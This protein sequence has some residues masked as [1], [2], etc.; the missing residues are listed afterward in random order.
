MAF[1]NYL[2]RLIYLFICLIF[3]QPISAQGKVNIDATVKLYQTVEDGCPTI[4][5]IKDDGAIKYQ[6]YRKSPDS[7]TWGNNYIAELSSDSTKY[8][9]CDANIQLVYEY[10]VIKFLESGRGYGFMSTG[11][12]INPNHFKGRVLMLIDKPSYDSIG[13]EIDRF[14]TVIKSEGWK[15]NRLII[16][17]DSSVQFIKSE[18]YKTIE[19][20]GEI[21]RI[22]IL[23]HVAVPHSGNIYPDGH[24]NHQGAWS[25]D[26]YYG[27]LDGNWTDASI[28]NVSSS[29]SNNHNIPNDGRFDQ[30]NIPSD[31]DIAVGRVDFYDLPAFS[32]NEFE[33]LRKYIQKSIAYRTKQFIPRRRALVQDNFNFVEAFGQSGLRGFSTLVS[34]DSIEYNNFGDA[35]NGSYLWLYGAGGGSYSSASGICNT[36]KLASDSLQGVFTLLFGSYFG[37]YDS[38]NNLMRSTIASGTA[39]SCAWAGRPHWAIH[40]MAMGADLG[41]CTLLSQNNN[42]LYPT[43]FSPRSVHVNLIGDPTL[44]SFVVAPPSNLIATEENDGHIL[45]E[46]SMSGEKV[47]G[48][49]L[50]KRNINEEQ[51]ELVTGMLSDRFYIDSCLHVGQKLEYL[52]RAVKVERTS[53]GSYYNLSGGPTYQITPS[54]DHSV[55]ADFSYLSEGFILTTTNTSANA[56]NYEW[57]VDG[58]SFFDSVNITID[59]ALTQPEQITLIANNECNSDTITLDIM[60]LGTNNILANELNVWPNPAR[61]I[62][63]VE[64]NSTIDKIEIFSLDGRA[65]KLYEFQKRLDISGLKS[66]FYILKAT[67]KDGVG[68]KQFVIER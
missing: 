14:E 1:L 38:K 29:N 17:R 21:D 54:T 19:D 27:E 52:V 16:E 60:V 24:T 3:M 20:Y 10:R 58:I 55:K 31:I 2:K 33:L 59:Y 26:L 51:F 68:I 30:S 23:G 15:V 43:G 61:K 12:L 56:T 4:N 9:D 45:L 6:I 64:C 18:I 48:Y 8:K 28:N 13:N 39:L 42:V 40:P 22:L 41:E 47:D 34:P 36:A 7:N 65:L 67:T 49:F 32:E 11:N 44:T 50:Y 46:W 62:I 63:N 53:S 66:G 25:A 57:I 5:W 35:F 37:D